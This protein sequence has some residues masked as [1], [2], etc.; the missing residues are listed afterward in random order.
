MKKLA[1]AALLLLL[2]GIAVLDTG[3][4]CGRP[5]KKSGESALLALAGEFRTVFANLL[6]IKVDQ[7][8][9][10]YSAH[11][12]DWTKNSDALGLTRIITT[13]DPHFDE[14]YA[15]GS[16]M[17]VGMDKPRDARAY[18][19]E[20]VT[21]NPNSLLLHDEMGTFLAVHMKDYKGS[22]FHLKKAYCIAKRD[23]VRHSNGR[24][25]TV[26]GPE[27]Q[28]EEMNDDE[29]QMRRLKRLIATV[30]RLIREDGRNA[31]PHN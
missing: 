23:W 7:Y 31:N 2:C 20:G 12:G 27:K 8:H 10:E 30:E 5:P 15:T 24:G 28:D 22:L 13:L 16:L 14:A 3:L 29:F 19:E 11:H 9:H 21:N 26:A 4:E 6:W 17:M 18:L 1:A 25:L